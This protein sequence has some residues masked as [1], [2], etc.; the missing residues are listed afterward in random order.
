MMP[1]VLNGIVWVPVAVEPDDCRLVDRT[2]HLRLATT[3][4]SR[5]VV[6]VSRKLNGRDLQTVMTHEVAHCA[7]WSYGLLD[8][9]HGIVPEDSWVDV[10]EWACNLVADFGAE[11]IEAAGR[12]LSA[13]VGAP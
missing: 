7:L 5:C 10:E 9:L 13:R 1:F 8:S 2:G 12:A 6:Y 3:D 11:I 4:T